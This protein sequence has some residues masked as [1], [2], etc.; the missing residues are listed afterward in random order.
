[1]IPEAYK[2]LDVRMVDAYLPEFLASHWFLWFPLWQW[3][4]I[5]LLIPVSFG[6]SVLVT[7]LLSPL[8]LLLVKRIARGQ[9]EQHVAGL[10]SNNRIRLRSFFLTSSLFRAINVIKGRA[11]CSRDGTSLSISRKTVIFSRFADMS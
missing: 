7:R 11:I 9:G 10:M 6:V 4:L 3:L 1:M 2:A 8:L 5:L